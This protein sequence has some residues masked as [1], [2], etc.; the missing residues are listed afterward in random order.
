MKW[1][2]RKNAHVDRIACP[3]LIRRFVDREAE[4]LFVGTDGAGDNLAGLYSL[5]ATCEAIFASILMDFTGKERSRGMGRGGTGQRL[6]GPGTM[7]P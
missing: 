6:Q 5:V 1:V 4:F 3:W 7:M 2:T